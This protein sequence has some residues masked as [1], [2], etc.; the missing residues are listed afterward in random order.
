MTVIDVLRA[1]RR[2]WVATLACLALTALA[3]VALT[4]VHPVYWSATDVRLVAPGLKSY[5]NALVTTTDSVIATAG[6]LVAEIN[7]TTPTPRFSTDQVT[8]VDAGITDGVLVR[9]P[10]SGG[11]WATNFDQPVITIQVAGPDPTTVR[12]ATTRMV[13]RVTALLARRQADAGVAQNQLITAYPTPAV[14][15]VTAAYGSRGKAML[16]VGLLGTTLS[17]GLVLF[18]DQLLLRRRTTRP[19]VTGATERPRSRARLATSDIPVMRAAVSSE[20]R[21]G[22]ELVRFD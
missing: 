9:L 18:L 6:L 14:P 5:T 15:V 21:Q 13:E 3:S 17:A 1:L 16:V 10:N 22:K 19:G 4:Q 11:Q 7:A 12:V 20:P 2:R 8:V